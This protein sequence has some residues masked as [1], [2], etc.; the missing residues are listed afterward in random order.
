MGLSLLEHSS[1]GSSSHDRLDYG[2]A[3]TYHPPRPPCTVYTPPHA[4][5]GLA[6]VT[7]FDEKYQ[8]TGQ[9]SGLTCA[10]VD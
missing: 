4:E 10:Y 9:S 8:K 5:V 2:S 1:W 3:S 7:G 6:R